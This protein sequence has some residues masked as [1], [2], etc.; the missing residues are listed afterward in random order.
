MM[1]CQI[2]YD[3]SKKL[4]SPA[5]SRFN[6]CPDVINDADRLSQFVS[7]VQAAEW[8]ALDPTFGQPVADATHLALGR[9]NQVDTVGLL[10]ALQVVAAEPVAV[11]PAPAGRSRPGP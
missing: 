1:R 11:A 6:G 10:G 5:R 3:P 4:F 2:Q 9:G 7:T 8:I